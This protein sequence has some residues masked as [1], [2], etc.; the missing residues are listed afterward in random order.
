MLLII[1]KNHFE[2]VSKNEA[3]DRSIYGTKSCFRNE[4]I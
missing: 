4:S 2:K 3:A 1:N